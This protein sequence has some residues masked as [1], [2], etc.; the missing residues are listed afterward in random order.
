[1]SHAKARLGL[2]TGEQGKATAATP[3]GT[4]RSTL[5]AVHHKR[6]QRSSC[7]GPQDLCCLPTRDRS[8]SCCC[9]TEGPVSDLSQAPFKNSL[10]WYQGLFWRTCNTLL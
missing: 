2:M 3:K 10:L 6:K 7:V 5:F 8:A 4:L 1:M 9:F